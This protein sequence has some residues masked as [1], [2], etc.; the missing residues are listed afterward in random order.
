M[1]DN[2]ARSMIG[3]SLI[4]GFAVLTGGYLAKGKPVI[5]DREGVVSVF[6]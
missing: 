3:C 1:K 4:C 6:V 5:A 2:L